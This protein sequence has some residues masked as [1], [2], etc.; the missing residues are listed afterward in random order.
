MADRM[1]ANSTGVTAGGYNNI[2]STAAQTNQNCSTATCTPAQLATYDAYDWVT[3]YVNN[4]KLLPGGS[5]T[6]VKNPADPNTFIIAITW[7]ERTG[8]AISGQSTAA[9]STPKTI[10]VV[11]RPL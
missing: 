10:T 8:S 5:A 9:A 11:F 6:V 4:A 2:D 3:N 7:N 1:R